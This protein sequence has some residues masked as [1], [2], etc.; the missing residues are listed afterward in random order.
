MLG[1]VNKA[2]RVLELFTS[3]KSEWGVTEVARALNMP[4]SSAHSLLTALAATNLLGRT[5][6]N[7]YKLGWRVLSLSRTLLDSSDVRMHAQPALHTLAHRYGVTAHVATLDD[8]EVTYIDKVE[9]G[10]TVPILVSGVGRRLPAHSTALG[11]VLLAYESAG[12][13]EQ[14]FGTRGL[15]PMTDQTIT[16]PRALHAELEAV[17]RQGWA[18][19]DEEIVEGLVCYAAPI[20]DPELGIEAAVSVSVS[21]EEDRARPDRYVRLAIAAATQVT[22]K[23]RTTR[24]EWIA[25]AEQAPVATAV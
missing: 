7:R 15:E 9:A 24:G 8:G 14:L 22:R 25:E 18:R 6:D 5:G 19:A 13:L 11:K 3:T 17:R 16:S 1:T 20:V 12:T 23:L 2:G 4:K 21:V 10:G